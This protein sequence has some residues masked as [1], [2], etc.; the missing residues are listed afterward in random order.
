MAG[1]F[2]VKNG[3]IVND[4]QAINGII[5]D[6]E[7]VNYS[8]VLPN[9]ML[10]TALATI[11][12]V[13]A[14]MSGVIGGD[15]THNGTLAIQGGGSGEFY[16][17]TQYQYDY[18]PELITH[19]NNLTKHRT[20]DDTDTTSTIRLWSANKINTEL[21]AKL[22]TDTFTTHITD[23]SVHFTKSSIVPSDIGLGSID[24]TA[25]LDKPI[26]TATQTALDLKATVS[27]VSTHT[28]DSTIHR[29]IN[30]AGTST[31]DLWSAS[32]I[33]TQIDTKED[34]LGS[35][36]TDGYILSST[37]AGVRSWVAQSSGGTGGTTSATFFYSYDATITDGTYLWPIG[38]FTDGAASSLTN[39]YWPMPWDGQIT[40]LSIS[41]LGGTSNGTDV[42][43]DVYVNGVL[44][45]EARNCN[46][47]GQGREV[48]FGTPIPFSIGDE[49]AIC[50][51]PSTWSLN[52]PKVA[53]IVEKV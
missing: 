32:Q 20:I 29:S 13:D 49:V 40:V 7:L 30:D 4:T 25:D 52:H 6:S 44:S 24:N 42:G 36:S 22:N 1:E 50:T 48:T 17:L 27:D 15:V 19:S 46:F 12:L 37:A 34:A 2:K 26:S 33:G 31:T 16:H 45:G 43:F 10:T 53:M 41:A 39:A 5:S 9:N 51:A 8:G 35:P 38:S 18:I 14:K 11:N 3:I 28:T 21:S 47:A 23:T